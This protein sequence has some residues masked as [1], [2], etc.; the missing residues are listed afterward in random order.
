MHGPFMNDRCGLG[1][2]S[3]CSRSFVEDRNLRLNYPILCY[4]PRSPNYV[5]EGII[6]TLPR[7]QMQFEVIVHGT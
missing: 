6:L 2:S 3:C 7:N 4:S 5:I 1:L